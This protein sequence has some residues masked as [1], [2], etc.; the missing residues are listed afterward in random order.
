VI[1]KEIEL[2]A[3]RHAFDDFPNESVGVVQG[4]NYVR[5]PNVARE[6]D[7][8]FELG[9]VDALA[10]VQSTALVHSHTNGQRH[11]S[12]EDVRCQEQMQVP[13]LVL[14]MDRSKAHDKIG[15]PA[16][17][18]LFWFGDQVPIAPYEG[19][20]HRWH[21]HDCYALARD[22]YKQELGIVLPQVHREF[23][24]WNQGQNLIAEVYERV[25]FRYVD[26]VQPQVGDLLVMN[27]GAIVPNHL[28]VYIGDG[29]MLHHPADHLSRK[30]LVHRWKNHH[31]GRY[32]RYVG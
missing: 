26:D 22:W 17:V 18:D 5:L 14:V 2:E 24:F 6:P 1:T 20:K 7:N 23:A 12:V 29:M 13:W 9:P 10:A 3:I 25:G 16:L 31:T 8:E 21:V 27:V 11:P 30:A 4:G 15:Q 19:R 28:G 32:L